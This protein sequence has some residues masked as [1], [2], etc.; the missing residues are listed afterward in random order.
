MPRKTL[1]T[2][3]KQENSKKSLKS[4]VSRFNRVDRASIYRGLAV[5]ICRQREFF[6]AYTVVSRGHSSESAS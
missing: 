2:P 3:K 1:D 6:S 4:W 5:I